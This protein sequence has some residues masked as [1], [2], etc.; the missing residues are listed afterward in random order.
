MQSSQ[1]TVVWNLVPPGSPPPGPTL[2][3]QAKNKPFA[4]L[5]SLEPPRGPD[6]FSMEKF[7]RPPGQ[8]GGVGRGDGGP[9]RAIG[10]A[11]AFVNGGERQEPSRFGCGDSFQTPAEAPL[12]G[13]KVLALFSPSLSQ[14][15]ST[16]MTPQRQT[17]TQQQQQQQQQAGGFSLFG[18]KA[19][20]TPCRSSGSRGE[21]R[22]PL[23]PHNPASSRAG[24]PS[25]VG[26]SV[27][28]GGLP[29]FKT[30]AQT[31]QEEEEEG[32]REAFGRRGRGSGS[33]ETMGY[34]S[35]AVRGTISPSSSLLSPTQRDDSAAASGGGRHTFTTPSPSSVPSSRPMGSTATRKRP[36]AP[37]MVATGT[38]PATSRALP[39]T[40]V[41]EGGGGDVAL[42]VART[43]G[44]MMDAGRG[45]GAHQQQQQRQQ[46]Q[47]SARPTSRGGTGPDL[48]LSGTPS[49]SSRSPRPA[50]KRSPSKSP[51]GTGGVGPS[52]PQSQQPP[53]MPRRYTLADFE[54]ADDVCFNPAASLQGLAIFLERCEASGTLSLAMMWAD[55]TT[56][57]SATTVKSCLPSQSCFRWNCACGRQPRAQQATAPI[58]GAVVYLPANE[59]IVS[60]GAFKGIDR[61][62]REEDFPEGE[63]Y[64]LPLAACEG[65]DRE[66]AEAEGYRLPLSCEAGYNERWSALAKLVAMHTKKVV[67]NAQVAL[68]PLIAW[69]RRPQSRAF[70]ARA[71]AAAA[72]GSGDK[73]SEHGRALDGSQQ[74]P[75]GQHST[76]SG[77]FDPRVAAWMSD[78]GTTDKGLEFEA[79][80][81]SWLKGSEVPAGAEVRDSSDD[82]S[83]VIVAAVLR[84][85]VCCKRSMALAGKLSVELETAKML[86]ACEQ[87]EMPAISVLAGMEVS[88]VVFFPERVTRFS[89]ALQHHLESLERAAVMAVGGREFNLASPDQVADILFS[90]L[91]LPSPPVKPGSLHASTSAEVLEGLRGKHAVVAPILEF[92]GV[93]KYKTTYVDKLAERALGAAATEG[94]IP[95]R[96]MAGAGAVR[97]HAVW[98][99]TAART[100]RLSCLRPNLQQIPKSSDPLAGVAGVNVRDAF[101]AS[102]SF[103]LMAADY[104]QIE[105]RVL[106]DACRDP[107][108]RSLFTTTSL[109]G[110][111][112]NV[113]TGGGDVYKKLAAQVFGKDHNDITDAERTRAKVVC[114]GIIYGMGTPQVAKKLGTTES[115]AQ[116]LVR[117]FLRAF[118]GI[119]PF[120]AATRRS[121]REKGYVCTLTGRRRHLP[122]INNS[123]NA[124]AKAQAERQAINSVIQGTA[125]DIVKTAMV[126]V[127]RRLG[128][129]R[130]NLEEGLANPRLIMQIHD[131][132]VLECPA[133]E[134]DLER[135][136]GLLAECMEVEAPAML[137]IECPLTVNMMVGRS[138]AAMKILT[139][140]MFLIHLSLGQTSCPADYSLLGCYTDFHSNRLMPHVFFMVQRET[141]SAEYCYFLCDDGLSTH[142]G[143]QYSRECWCATNP[144][145]TKN[146]PQLAH[147]ECNMRCAGT[148]SGEYCG[149]YYKMLV[150]EI[151]SYQGCDHENPDDSLRDGL[152]SF[153]SS[154]DEQIIGQPWDFQEKYDTAKF[155]KS[156]GRRSLFS[157]GVPAGSC[158]VED[159]HK[160]LLAQV[161][162]WQGAQK[163]TPRVF[164]GIY[165]H[166]PNHATKVKAIQDTWASHCDGFV[167]FSDVADL[168]LNTFKIKH[169]GPEEYGNMW[170]KSRAIWKY[171]NFHY[172]EEFDWFLLGGDDFFVIMENLRKYLLSDEIESAAGGLKGGGTTPMYLGRRM[173]VDGVVDRIYNNGGPSYVLNQAAVSLL[174]SVI[175]DNAS[176]PHTRR[177][178][179]DLIVGRIM[180]KNG[181]QPFDT[182]DAFGR[183]RFHCYTPAAH[184]GFRLSDKVE[185][186]ALPGLNDWYPHS[187]INLKFGRECCS[188]DSVSFHHVDADLMRRLYHL[189][190]VCP[191]DTRDMVAAV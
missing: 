62:S 140:F 138:P 22:P 146:G 86:A 110:T 131:E 25:G 76:V 41:G 160:K 81:V 4:L 20:S 91:K 46:R 37:S 106:A 58:I 136:K 102:K 70:A 47:A 176:Q 77:L 42:P 158:D 28:G 80:C 57:F 90:Y 101:A 13:G 39:S 74:Q 89:V 100:G 11:Q 72:H 169:E 49:S 2:H 51:L 173:R 184:L 142:F 135:L 18:G 118:P 129:W 14:A 64:L 35:T 166:Q 65:E 7:R 83:P 115:Q 112:G 116:G 84:A 162:V 26:D 149:G 19:H 103:T 6:Y 127:A 185:D 1:P 92:R 27:I 137:G 15:S 71:A 93:N 12:A 150:Y 132:L 3:T 189:V 30:L 124:A 111:K 56:S 9:R 108:L 75:A 60:H 156:D 168:E 78:T 82:P 94:A 178:W 16:L 141:M 144:E 177:F 104:S 34:P 63:T 17:Q 113:G 180:K 145:L 36:R 10:G 179:E 29:R 43:W 45:R 107:G 44:G 48:G 186:E 61:G 175:D 109:G 55:L 53:P 139:L 183:E 143:L 68:M 174:A 153:S 8:D 32:E 182:R 38:R 66:A 126:L 161:N 117:S 190:Y 59:E 170:Q 98:N 85:Q 159:G 54:G 40:P 154:Q 120:L 69:S 31:R 24:M 187:A 157:N 88:G 79:L 52:S 155:F 130:C 21:R 134:E 33:G 148:T 96:Q 99:Q 172:R 123:R 164:C 105:M 163:T 73:E 97:I 133:C 167:A 181:V 128:A 5:K 125:A 67:F 121:A 114:L 191:K 122:E 152:L 147:G 23:S 119:G 188:H 87:V 171:I 165:T 151:T 50:R 95:A